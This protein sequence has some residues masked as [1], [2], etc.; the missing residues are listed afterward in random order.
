M[1]SRSTGHHRRGG[2]RPPQAG[3]GVQPSGPAR[4]RPHVATWAETAT[5]LAADLM[6]A[7]TPPLGV[8][9]GEH[10]VDVGSA[11]RGQHRRLAAPAHRHHPRARPAVDRTRRPRRPSHDRHPATPADPRSGPAGPPRRSAPS[12]VYPRDTTCSTRSSPASAACPRRPDPATT[13]PRSTPKPRSPEATL[14]PPGC[15]QPRNQNET[16]NTARKRSTLRLLAESGQRTTSAS[17]VT[18]STS[19]I[20][21]ARM[22][23]SAPI[24]ANAVTAVFTASGEPWTPAPAPFAMSAP[25]KL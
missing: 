15:P 4:G 14:G 20:V 19:S 23:S 2:L 9:A 25:A 21:G 13:A 7:S 11:A 10:R 16:I 12:C 8:S 22:S 6:A 18:S 17:R 3:R 24:S 1:R 5:V